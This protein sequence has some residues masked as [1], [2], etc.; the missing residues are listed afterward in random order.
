[1]SNLWIGISTGPRAT[2]VLAM[3][4]AEE[5]ILKARLLPEPSQPRA[6][7]TLL[8]AV[9]MWQ[10]ER[11][12]VVLS[13]ADWDGACD[14]S[15]CREAFTDFGG[16]LYSLDWVPA[17]GHARRRARRERDLHGVGAF[18]DLRNLLLSEVVR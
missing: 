8:Q 14:S 18:A 11:A 10:G 9:A 6:L 4:G 3:Q 16:P 1:M 7:T 13:V 15:L 17:C 5:T 2:G 12:R